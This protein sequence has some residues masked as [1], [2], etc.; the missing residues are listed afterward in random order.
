MR[1]RKWTVEHPLGTLHQWMGATHFQ[2]RK[3]A[4]VSAEMSLN[5]LAYKLKRVMKIIG[6]NCLM[7]VLST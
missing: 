6:A 7:K 4:W 3:L 1:I 5:V 2:T